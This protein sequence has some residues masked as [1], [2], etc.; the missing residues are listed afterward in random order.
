MTTE[1]RRVLCTALI[2]IPI[3]ICFILMLLNQSSYYDK[4]RSVKVV[5]VRHYYNYA[6]DKT[7]KETQTIYI[8]DLEENQ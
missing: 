3:F 7:K 5:E 6:K 4:I 2:V 8:E 1:T